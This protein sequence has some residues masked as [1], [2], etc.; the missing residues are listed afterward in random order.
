LAA[1]LKHA[2]KLV[3]KGFIKKQ[4]VLKARKALESNVSQNIKLDN[5]F[6][7][8]FEFA[9]H[10]LNNYW[11]LKP[12]VKEK[13]NNFIKQKFS[14]DFIIGLQMRF[15]YLNQEDIQTF[16]NC[17]LKIENDNK[18]RIGNR[19]VKW[20]ISTDQNAQIQ[21]LLN[22]YSDRILTGEGKIG[23]VAF[24]SDAYE[25]AI[26]DIELLSH[27]NETI[28]TGGSTFGFIG[29]LKSQKIP[30]FVEGKRSSNECK[31]LDF[32]APA[33]R[34]AGFSVF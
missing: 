2:E 34:P 4:T 30:Y 16:V 20:F 10:V 25:R 12:N 5:L 9:G 3:S 1:N 13:I 7:I 28:L 17:A 24:E 29:S 11:L 33:R 6:Q 31:L 21:N 19:K 15:E 18:T 22:R 32:H 23:H 27:C 14:G 8:G 26:L